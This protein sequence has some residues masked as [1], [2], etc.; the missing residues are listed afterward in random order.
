M[1]SDLLFY[2]FY[3]CY[4]SYLYRQLFHNYYWTM[5]RWIKYAVKRL[6]WLLKTQRMRQTLPKSR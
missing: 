6:W 2:I 3:I 1:F 5:E 4:V